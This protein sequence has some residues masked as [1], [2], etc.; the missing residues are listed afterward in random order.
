MQQ[1]I[2]SCISL[3]LAIIHLKVISGKPLIITDLPGAQAFCIHELLKI[4]MIG[5][6]K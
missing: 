1:S 2:I 5:K 6:G 4:V 3:A